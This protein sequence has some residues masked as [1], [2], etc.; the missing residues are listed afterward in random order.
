MGSA[1][2]QFRAALA[3]AGVVLAA[4]VHILPDGKLH[5]AKTQDDKPGQL[6][7][8][9]RL[10][11]DEP[12]AGVGGDW[13][14]GVSVR[15]C[16]RRPERLTARE[17]Q[18]LA[19]R[20]QRER[21]EA[22]QEQE[23]RHRA[24]AQRAAHIWKQSAPAS[25]R[26]PYLTRKQIAPGIARQRGDMLI[27]PVTG[28]DGDLRGIQTISP[29]G[30]K[31]F[32]PG[33]RKAGGF[34]AINGEPRPDARLLIAE[35]FATASTLAELSPGAVVLAGLDAGNLQAVA[36]EARRRWPRIDLVI[37]ADADAVG[38]AKAKAAAEASRARW[39]WPRFPA[40]APEGLSDFNDWH[41]W[42]KSQRR[43]V[44]HG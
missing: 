8:W 16:S 7:G 25:P 43:G 15:W 35:G 29:K 6:S 44:A 27:L 9:Y 28:F 14:K 11:L 4:G 31:R 26:H 42:R 1:I 33:M 19:A 41:T 40:D 20:I 30:E 2:E 36:V 5:R 21:A 24:A 22:E 34:I 18:E 39:I 17:R 37:A 23:R 10:H 12:T 13:R 32:T 3:S 38:M